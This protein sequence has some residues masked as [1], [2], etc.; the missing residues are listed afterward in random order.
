M[1]LFITLL[2]GAFFLF[3]AEVIRIS[4]NKRA[5][6]QF[7][8]A[9]A[10]GALVC[11]AF[12]DL[13]PDII[14]EY[15]GGRVWIAIIL[16]V[17]GLVFLQLL[18]KYVPDHDNG[19]SYENLIHIGKMAVIAI[20]LHNV[21]EGMTVYSIAHNSITSGFSLAVGV[22]LHN[23]P[24]GMMIWSTIKNER[25][26]KKYIVMAAA[27]L[28]TFAGGLFMALINGITPTEITG[29]LVCVALGMV[30]Y[31]IVFELIPSIN[32]DRNPKYSVPG[33]IIGAAFVLVSLLF[34]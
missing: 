4:K 17:A 3:G 21:A 26:K 8:I 22:G 33:I 13:I 1:A 5:V 19:G 12:V 14:E 32:S 24:M 27:A 28:S 9:A 6:E 30:I 11:M 23:I 15:T 20:S 34:E 18:D 16:T 29:P 25:R 10:F 31:I 7:S 2:L